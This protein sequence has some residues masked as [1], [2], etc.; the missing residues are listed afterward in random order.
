MDEKR[1]NNITMAKKVWKRLLQGATMSSISKELML[2][3]SEICNIKK[4]TKPEM[5][6]SDEKEANMYIDELFEKRKLV[7]KCKCAI[8]EYRAKLQ[9][10]QIELDKCKQKPIEKRVD[11]EGI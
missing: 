11:D 4:Y 6:V 8:Q 1:K 2:H 9:N 5:Y 10:L 7:K 3:K